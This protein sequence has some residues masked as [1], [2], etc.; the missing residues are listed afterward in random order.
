[1]QRVRPRPYRSGIAVIC[2]I[3]VS[4]V[5]RP[6]LLRACLLYTS[7]LKRLAERLA[8]EDEEEYRTGPDVKKGS[9]GR[10]FI[11]QDGVYGEEIL[12]AFIKIAGNGNCKAVWTTDLRCV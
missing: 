5:A 1:M 8:K 7:K 10:P 9:W 2:R 12:S 6:Y 11:K 4:V 3:R